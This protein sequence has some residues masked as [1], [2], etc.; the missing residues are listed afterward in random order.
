MFGISGTELII[1]LLFAFLI[2]GPDKLPDA[3]KAI[4]KAIGKFQSAQDQMNDVIKTETESIKKEVMGSTQQASE[5]AP[6]KRTVRTKVK[7]VTPE[8]TAAPAAEQETTDDQPP[9]QMSFSERKALYEKERAAKREA[10]KQAAASAK[11]GE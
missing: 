8:A 3:A 2:V 9:R 11:D 6:A 1:I 5:D 4:G 10:E 7:S